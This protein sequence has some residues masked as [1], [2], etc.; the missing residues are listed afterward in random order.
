MNVIELLG[1]F[2]VFDLALFAGVIIAKKPL[3]N[4][5]LPTSF[6]LV[7]YMNFVLFLLMIYKREVSSYPFLFYLNYILAYLSPLYFLCAINSLAGIGYSRCRK[8]AL[9]YLIPLALLISF[10]LWFMLQ[11]KDFRNAF[12]ESIENHH[13]PVFL[14]VIN[15]VFVLQVVAAAIISYKSLNRKASPETPSNQNV[16]SNIKQLELLILLFLMLF[17]PLVCYP[18]EVKI[19]LIYSSLIL[20]VLHIVLLSK[21]ISKLIPA[22][23]PEKK[24]KL[25]KSSQTFTNSFDPVTS[26][27]VAP[28]VAL[29]L[30]EDAINRFLMYSKKLMEED[31]IFKNKNFTVEELARMSKTPKYLVAQLINMLYG[32]SFP[33]YVNQYRVAE[34]KRLMRIPENRRYNIEVLAQMSG[35]NSRST[36]YSTF[37][38]HV[39]VTPAQYIKKLE[40]LQ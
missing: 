34:A 35:F 37:K 21:L 12:F 40:E 2:T 26:S 29:Q 13:P 10:Y 22:S 8:S 14:W 5:N 38:Q 28:A 36:F 32:M 4:A 15:L 33:E 7:A 25:V 19:A 9:L 31:Q 39:G 6:I 18:F 11:T 1:F 24:L 30:P 16:V 3:I 23:L 20:I 27:V 17:L